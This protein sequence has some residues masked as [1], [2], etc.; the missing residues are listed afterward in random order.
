[1]YFKPNVREEL[2]L[3]EQRTLKKQQNRSDSESSD[4][5]SD[6]NVDEAAASMVM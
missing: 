4:E 6:S 5:M 2:A 1:M 3:D